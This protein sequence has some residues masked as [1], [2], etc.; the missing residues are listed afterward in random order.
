MTGGARPAVEAALFDLGKVL[1]DWDPRYYYRRFFDDA[2]ALE[3]F[4]AEVIAPDWILEM[5]AGKPAREAIAERQARFPEHAALIARWS[6]GWPLMLKGE[7]AGTAA[8]VGELA[9]RGTRLFALTNFSAET[10][11]HARKRIPSLAHFA[12]IV[13]SAEVGVVKPDPRIYAI[14]IER[15]GLDPARTVFVDDVPV[16]V[17]A[18]RAAGFVALHFTSAER[19]RADLAP[20]GLP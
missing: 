6:E 17:E 2:Q 18:G 20:L 10:F 19:L 5:D 9:A 11:P 4:V 14:A 1:L 3:R 16:N 12:D 7:I 8:I 13:M 15:C